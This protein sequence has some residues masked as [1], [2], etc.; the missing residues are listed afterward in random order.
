M[1]ENAAPDPT[2]GANQEKL[3]TQLTRSRLAWKR[4]VMRIKA[5][6]PSGFAQFLLTVAVALLIIWILWKTWLALTPFFVGAIVAY[7]VLPF[8]NRL[9]RYMPRVM[10]IVL[11]LLAVVALFGVFL[12]QLVPIIGQQVFRFTHLLP[13]KD[14]IRQYVDD[15]RQW[16]LTLPEPPQG[17]INNP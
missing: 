10:A 16:Y 7:V 11:V 1:A 2:S 3:E 5:I 8:V 13:G 12:S 4:L 9:D 6:T 17:V 14:D 15:L